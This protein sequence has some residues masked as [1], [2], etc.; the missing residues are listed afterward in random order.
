L[1]FEG[2]ILAMAPH[3]AVK[4]IAKLVGEHDTRIWRMIRHHVKEARA[5]AD[6]SSVRRMAFD[7]TAALRGH[8][9]VTVAVDLDS[10]R[11]LFATPGKDSSCIAS[12]AAD[13]RQHGGDP[14]LVT[15]QRQLR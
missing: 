5:R 10:R 2:L 7:E 15:V 6:H 8:D 4:N 14:A 11:V 1:L 9:Y 3:M 13:L 12:A